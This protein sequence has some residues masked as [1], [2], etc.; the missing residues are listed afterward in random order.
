MAYSAGTKLGPYEIV[1]PI[2][3]GGMGEV[4]RAHDSRLQ[5][6]VA[7]KVSVLRL[8]PDA[9]RKRLK[10][11]VNRSLIVCIVVRAVVA[12]C[13]HQ[14]EKAYRKG[15]VVLSTYMHE[16]PSCRNGMSVCVRNE[17]MPIAF[18]PEY[19]TYCSPRSRWL[20]L[21]A[22]RA[23]RAP[24]SIAHPQAIPCGKWGVRSESYGTTSL[25]EPMNV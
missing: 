13:R 4:Y 10:M 12:S 19:G 11:I 14:C 3:A 25:R 16:S 5:R 21:S 1:A 6:D 18:G 24:I 9:Y 17:R 8:R 20:P 23:P 7:I 2:G 15:T 22:L